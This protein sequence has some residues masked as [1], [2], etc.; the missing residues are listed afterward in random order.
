MSTHT[1]VQ[2]ESIVIKKVKVKKGGVIFRGMALPALVI[3]LWQ[4]LSS[5]G[6]LPAQLFSSPFLIISRFI[7]LIRSG[8]IA[9]HLQI[10]LTRAFLGFALG[11]F[12]GLFIGIIVGMNK[13]QN[14]I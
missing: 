12:L 3:V 5:M 11:S 14:N 8:E 1:V 9:V 10:S 4:L 13:N 6:L 7:E 2:N